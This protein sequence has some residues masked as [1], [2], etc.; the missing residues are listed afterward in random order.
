MRVEKDVK[1]ENRTPGKVIFLIDAKPI[2]VC[3]KGLI[4]INE[5][6]DDQ[7]RQSLLPMSK[8][9]SRFE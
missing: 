3:G 2:V 7:T 8:F 1:I 5:M 6:V 4:K 9:R